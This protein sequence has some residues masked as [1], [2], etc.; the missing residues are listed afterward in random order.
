M[1]KR[2]TLLALA[3]TV[4]LLSGFGFRRK[5]AKSPE[6]ID[7][8][9]IFALSAANRFLIDWEGGNVGDGMSLASNK[10]RAAHPNGFLEQYL[11]SDQNPKHASFEVS[12]G[13][14]LP[15]G[16]VEFEVR[17]YEYQQGQ[18]W[19]GKRPKPSRI[20]LVR[21]SLESWLVDDIP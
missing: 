3:A 4:L 5:K 7:Q 17:L 19:Q 15:D 21:T 16:R 11:R 6:D 13:K 14:K 8:D 9:Y 10:L 12:N 18:F 1:M 2:T 20:T